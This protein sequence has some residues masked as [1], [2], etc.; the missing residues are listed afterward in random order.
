M[1]RVPGFQ[2]PSAVQASVSA[3]ASTANQF[4]ALSRPFPTTVRQQP[5]QAIEEMHRLDAFLDLSRWT[6]FIADALFG[7]KTSWRRQ[8]LEALARRPVRARKVWLLVR[9]DLLERE[10]IA[11]MKRASWYISVGRGQTTDQAALIDA[12]ASGHVACAGLDVTDP[13][14]LPPASPLWAMDNVIITPHISGSTNRYTERASEIF[15]E[16]LGAYIQTGRPVRNVVDYD[17]QY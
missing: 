12:L 6:L 11:L 15:L 16:N 1:T 17:R 3:E 5:E 14:P 7:M 8:F 4:P 9:I 13:E 10:D 2:F